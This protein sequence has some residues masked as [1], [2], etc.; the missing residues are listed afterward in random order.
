MLKIDNIE[1]KYLML[2][3]PVKLTAMCKEK[4]IFLALQ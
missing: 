4:E 3:L 1:S 2:Y